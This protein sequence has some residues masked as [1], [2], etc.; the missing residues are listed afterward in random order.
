MNKGYAESK[1]KDEKGVIKRCEIVD[2]NEFSNENPC[3]P[4]IVLCHIGPQT[5]T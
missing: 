4:Y 2:I 1:T 5:V 3:K